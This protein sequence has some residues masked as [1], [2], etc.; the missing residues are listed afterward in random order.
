MSNQIKSRYENIKILDVWNCKSLREVVE[1][2]G[3]NIVT[4]IGLRDIMLENT[5]KEIPIVNFF[6]GNICVGTAKNFRKGPV[7]PDG[8]IPDTFVEIHCDIECNENWKEDYKEG[9]G[10]LLPSKMYIGVEGKG[11]E[12]LEMGISFFNWMDE[13]ER[14]V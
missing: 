5:A 1:K 6:E 12:I 10:H 13:E 9:W 4:A 2:F 11:P 3:N 7:K 8:S 14:K